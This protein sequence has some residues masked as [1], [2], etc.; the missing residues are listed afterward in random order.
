MVGNPAQLLDLKV[1]VKLLNFLPD[2]SNNH[3]D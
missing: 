2:E 3:E 1:A